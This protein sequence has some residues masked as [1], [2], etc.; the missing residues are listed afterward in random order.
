[1]VRLLRYGTIF[2]PLKD[3]W[4]YLYKSDLYKRRIEAGPEPERFRSS[5]INWNYDAELYACTHRFGEKMNIESLRNA[6][7]DASFLNQII[8][9]RTE[10]GLAATDQTTLSF[11]HNEELAKRGKQIA[12]NFL[13][14]AL[15][16]WY[17]KFPQEGIDAVTK[18]LISESTIAYI[19]SKLGFKTLIRCDVPL[20]RPTM[21]QNALFAFIGAIDENNNQSRAELF[22]ADFILTHLVGKDMNEIWHV[23]N[24]MGLL[25][26]VLEENGRQAPESRLIWATG[27]SSVLSTYVVGVYSNKE[28]LGK[29]A[30]ATISLAEEMAARDALRRFAHASEG[31]EPAYHHVISGYKIYKHENEPFRLKYNNKSLNEFQLA[32]ETWGKL[33]AKKNNAVLIFTGLSASS[34]A[35]SHDENPRAGWWEKFI[36]PNLGI[37][38][39]HFFVICCNHLGGCYGS[40]GPSSKNPKTNKPYGASFP[41]LSV[42]D[43]VRA[44]FHLIKHLGIEKLHASIGSSL[45]GMCSILSGLLYPDNVGRVASISSCIAPYP[46][47]I[48]LRYLQ[49]KMIMTDPNWE[50]GHYYDK[51]VY[52]LD[53]MRI[54]REI[55]T[56]TY[57]SGPEW[58]ERFGLRR[59]N[60]TIQLTPTFEIESYLQ[61]Q[62]LTFAKKYDP[63]SLLY[64]SK[65][66]DLFNLTEG[67][68]TPSDA[69]SKIRCPVLVLGSQTDILFP[70]WQQ[71]QL[72]EELIKSGNPSITFFEL[73]SIFGHD[74]FLLDVNGVS[75]AL[76]GFLEISALSIEEETQT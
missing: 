68:E 11:T 27:V 28:F 30:G 9:Q 10:A 66:M 15:Q 42:E 2:G 19:S 12:E 69:L 55:G 13:R 56:L 34:H 32:Y 18:F 7:T 59:F 65:A 31:P 51:G 38:T 22:V 35:K 63:N 45:G 3:R 76:K 49:R 74:T 37:D 26:T 58:L 48:A 5:L 8:K 25:T 4:R 75:T 62:G 29:S 39:N 67:Y 54:A 40:T 41:M 14:R 46:T 16:Y 64:I 36:G 44:Q 60:D 47:A 43:F 73:N 24:P 6:M 17:P 72:A 1:M 61:Y 52:P 23:K 57:R 33:N 70:I 50:H 71:K 20:P 21:L 53:G